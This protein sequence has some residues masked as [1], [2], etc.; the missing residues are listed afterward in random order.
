MHKGILIVTDGLD[1]IGK[2]VVNKA[3]ENYFKEKGKKIFDIHDFWEKHDDHPELQD[4]TSKYY[5]NIDDYDII[6]S[7]EPTFVGI[8]KAIR[9]ELTKKQTRKYSAHTT[10]NAYSMDREIL[11]KRV[12]I[13][14]LEKGKIIVQSRSI[15][16]SIVYQPIQELIEGET[17][18]TIQ[19]IIKLEGNSLALKYRPD[20]LIIP[21]IK[22]A[23]IVMERLEKREKKD[24]SRFENTEF[25][26]KI[27]PLYESE[28]I[29]NIFEERGTIVK[30]MDNGISIESTKS[31]AINILEEFL[32][33]KGL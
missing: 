19:D 13:P 32:K 6:L 22:D 28:K 2:G 23:K 30:Y 11:L 25:Q 15:S 8:G 27:K 3:I 33:T 20:L 16:T 18:L 5:V 1:G 9:N 21:T 12:I 29:K 26:L 7:S 4:K 10:A 17:P 31:Q 24:D 14:S